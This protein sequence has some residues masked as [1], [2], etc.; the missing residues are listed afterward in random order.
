MTKEEFLKRC[1]E[2]EGL[3]IGAKLLQ[4]AH[5]QHLYEI[6]E[7]LKDFCETHQELFPLFKRVPCGD[8]VISNIFASF[9]T[10]TVYFRL[11]ENVLGEDPE[12]EQYLCDFDALFGEVK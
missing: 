10:Q 4:Q 6:R 12:W 8:V 7:F 5:S 11:A 2:A 3:F 9:E 1:N